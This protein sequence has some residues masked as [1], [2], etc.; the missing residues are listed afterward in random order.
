MPPYVKNVVHPTTHVWRVDLHDIFVQI[1]T[2]GCSLTTPQPSKFCKSLGNISKHSCTQFKAF[3]CKQFL[4]IRENVRSGSTCPAFPYMYVTRIT[5]M[6]ITQITYMYITHIHN[7]YYTH[8]IYYKHNTHYILFTHHIYISYIPQ[9]IT[10]L[11][12]VSIH[13]L[14]LLHPLTNNRLEILH[15]EAIQTPSK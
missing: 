8:T 11:H 1:I 3:T 9:L 7:I 15:H 12:D 13:C 4:S 14:Q 2:N 6:Y 5:Y 10:K